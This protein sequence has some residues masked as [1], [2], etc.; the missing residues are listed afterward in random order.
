MAIVLLVEDRREAPWFDAL[1]KAVTPFGS[2]RITSPEAVLG[3][4]PTGD[5][6]IVILDAAAIADVPEMVR[7]I[8][9]QRPSVSVIVAGAAPS[10]DVARAA[11]RAGANDYIEK[12]LEPATIQSALR[13]LLAG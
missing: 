6:A 10:W 11:F 12:S 8:H 1:Q 3:D 9:A 5:D 4:L 7:V 13:D 2:L